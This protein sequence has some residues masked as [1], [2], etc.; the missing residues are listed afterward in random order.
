MNIR[1]KGFQ[2]TNIIDMVRHVTKYCAYV[3]RGEDIKYYLDQAFYHAT[4]GRPGPVVLDIPI[5]MQRVELDVAA[6]RGFV[7]PAAPAI[8]YPAIAATIRES[9]RQAAKPV[10][11]LGNSNT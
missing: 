10:V 4:E 11:I 9:L 3:D 1:Q 2:E 5:D 7:P 8:D 6:L